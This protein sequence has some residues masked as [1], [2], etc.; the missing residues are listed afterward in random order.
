MEAL[1]KLIILLLLFSCGKNDSSSERQAE[2]IPDGRDESPDPSVSII[3]C[4]DENLVMNS[5]IRQTPQKLH[6]YQCPDF[7]QWQDEMTQY[8]DVSDYEFKSCLGNHRQL[9]FCTHD[10]IESRESEYGTLIHL[11]GTS[12]IWCEERV[13]EILYLNAETDR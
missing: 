9:E 12:S 4:F 13:M 3:K 5:Q 6:F 10:A 1:S 2:N 8:T 11:Q 7:C